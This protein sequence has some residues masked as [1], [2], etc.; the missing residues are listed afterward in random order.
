[1]TA[2]NLWLSPVLEPLPK[3]LRR[4]EQ[5]CLTSRKLSSELVASLR[6]IGKILWAT[7]SHYASHHTEAKGARYQQKEIERMLE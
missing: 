3:E 4:K 1:M 6:G 7:Y 5:L 2:I